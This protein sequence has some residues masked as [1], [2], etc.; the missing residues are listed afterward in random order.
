MKI[1]NE[2]KIGIFA[3]VVVLLSIWG[4]K[5]LR[6]RNIIQT[7][8]TY[9]VRYENIDQLAVTSTVM[10]RG[11]SIGSVTKLKL[12]DDMKSIIA[13]LTIDKDIRIPKDAEA[14]VISTGIM[15]GKAVE[16]VFNQACNGPD[17]APSGSYLKGRVKG[18]LESMLGSKK[19]DA[20]ND[21]KEG[22][23]NILANAGET[24]TNI[25]ELV[26]HLANIMAVLDNSI[27]SY[28]KNLGASLA[29][30]NSLTSSLANNQQTITNLLSNLDTISA[31]FKSANIGGKASTT[32]AEAEVAIQ[33]LEKTLT[34]ATTTFSKLNSVVSK[35]DSNDGTLGKLLSD[36]QLY[37]N[38]NK[39]SRELNLLLQDFRL[40]PKRYVNVSVFGKKQ[41]A[42]EVPENDPAV[43]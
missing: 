28:D 7:A 39:S 4:Y 5:F 36:K 41:K 23:D 11:L 16:I 31:D 32:L 38:L 35:V 33:S 20:V 42:Y 1:S 9:Y 43:E 30:I 27:K 3:V 34:E 14:L 8:N 37:D 15:G 13:T 6:G 12:D 10:I 29:N 17:C 26:N 19:E 18:L 21:V 2:I 40:N 24:F 25:S 22:V